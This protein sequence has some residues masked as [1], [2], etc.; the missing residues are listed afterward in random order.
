MSPATLGSKHAYTFTSSLSSAIKKMIKT[1]LE[2]EFYINKSINN[3]ILFSIYSIL[4]K[5]Q[6][7]SFEGLIKECFTL[8]PEAFGFPKYQKWPD[9]RKLDRPLRLLRKKKLITGNPKTYFS[10][11]KTGKK[12]SSEVAETFRQRKL[13]F[14]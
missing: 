4:E 8:F 7:C 12:I 1:S 9:S 11:T 6:K 10:L 2:E 5:K 13:S 14:R 3:L